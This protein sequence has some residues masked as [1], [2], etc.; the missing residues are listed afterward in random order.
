MGKRIDF[1]V[2]RPVG[3]QV[4]RFV[5]PPIRLKREF[6][7]RNAPLCPDLVASLRRR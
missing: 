2:Q 4:R 5:T 3:R 6:H 7:R 1:M